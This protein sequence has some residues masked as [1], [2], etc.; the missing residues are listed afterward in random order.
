MTAWPASFGTIQEKHEKLARDIK[1]REL[2]T[3]IPDVTV[4]KP[5][6][7]QPAPKQTVREQRKKPGRGEGMPRFDI[8]VPP[9]ERKIAHDLWKARKE[10]LA[11]TFATAFTEFTQKHFKGPV[12][13]LAQTPLA[14]VYKGISRASGKPEALKIQL[15]TDRFLDNVLRELYVMQ[16]IAKISPNL[17]PLTFAD[18]LTGKEGTFLLLGMPLAN[19]NLEQ[20]LG[21]QTSI[22]Q[23]LESMY[24]IA[25][26]VASLHNVGLLHLDLKPANILFLGEQPHVADF[27]LLQWTESTFQE[28]GGNPATMAPEVYLSDDKITSAVDIWSLGIV[29]AQMLASFVKK[30]Y[31]TL[32]PFLEK[33]VQAVYIF[34]SGNE[35]EGRPRVQQI[36]EKELKENPGVKRVALFF[37]LT[38]TEEAKL[39]KMFPI[40]PLLE[41]MLSIDPTK[42]PDINEVL[43]YFES[44]LK[45]S[46]SCA[47]SLGV[48]NVSSE[49]PQLSKEEQKI[50]KVFDIPKQVGII[51]QT[52]GQDE[53][54]VYQQMSTI[55][56]TWHNLNLLYKIPPH[57][58]GASFLMATDLHWADPI[59]K[60]FGTVNQ[61]IDGELLDQLID[62]IQSQ[63]DV[64][65]SQPAP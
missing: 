31:A 3:V 57:L 36:L 23:L 15:I 34:L 21:T 18:V 38:T 5:V 24:Q 6:A 12:T 27:G 49:P 14:T 61:M 33:M 45:V 56:H 25:C 62:Y 54:K 63:Q 9:E 11:P 53:A 52:F 46:P 50:L 19:S 48:R 8:I 4:A 37:N 40:W 16:T 60:I 43:R 39:A 65:W 41:Q 26:G 42:R 20:R 58:L 22:K 44:K 30:K 51:T 1:Q 2:E 64:V 59:Y 35:L 47:Q 32:S 29:Y 13:V 17:I 28:K 10:A 55:L 7:E